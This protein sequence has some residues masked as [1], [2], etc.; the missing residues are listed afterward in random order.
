M[1][2]L[3]SIQWSEWGTLNDLV[4]GSLR[5][6]FGWGFWS[7]WCHFWCHF[8]SHFWSHFCG[9]LFL[10]FLLGWDKSGR[11]K[12]WGMTLC[13]RRIVWGEEIKEGGRNVELISSE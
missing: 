10:L 5:R 11:E 8:W 4:G 1:G 12:W 3:Q 13:G 2:C 9:D 7:F 6:D